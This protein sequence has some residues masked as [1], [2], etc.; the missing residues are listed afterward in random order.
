M[1]GDVRFDTYQ[2]FSLSFPR[3]LTSAHY[4]TVVMYLSPDISSPSSTSLLSLIYLLR[5]CHV[6]D[7]R[8]LLSISL[9]SS[10][11]SL[12]LYISPR[13]ALSAT[14]THTHTHT[15]THVLFIFPTDLKNSCG[16]RTRTIQSPSMRIEG[17]G[18]M[19]K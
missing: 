19:D 15:P 16:L 5:S 14:Y 4:H 8:Q 9:T 7:S 18:G 6:L 17:S 11:L 12:H 1:L 13:Y 10:F 3:H 2:C